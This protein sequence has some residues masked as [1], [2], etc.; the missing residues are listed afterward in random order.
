MQH[1]Q[2]K[3]KMLHFTNWAQCFQPNKNLR[4]LPEP[5]TLQSKGCVFIYSQRTLLCLK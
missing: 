1:S 5:Q 2:N 4:K 3:Q